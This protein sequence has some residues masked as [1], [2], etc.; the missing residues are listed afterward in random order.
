MLLPAEYIAR[1]ILLSQNA[2]PVSQK[3][4]LLSNSA[5]RSMFLGLCSHDTITL[6]A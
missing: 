6:C 3:L 5:L 4:L 2:M 1:Q